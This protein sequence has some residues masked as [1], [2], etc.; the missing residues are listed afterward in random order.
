M[1]SA[2]YELVQSWDAGTKPSL[3][4]VELTVCGVTH[5]GVSRIEGTLAPV[6]MS[7]TVPLTRD[8]GGVTPA[9]R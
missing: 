6:L 8:A 1:Q 3:I 4:T 5:S 2:A 9:R 7:F